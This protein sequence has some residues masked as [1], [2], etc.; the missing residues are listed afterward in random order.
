MPKTITQT[1]K[2]TY[3][4]NANEIAEK[5]T[6]SLRPDRIKW[7]K[8]TAAERNVAYSDIVRDLVDEARKQ[9]ERESMTA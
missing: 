7:I 6:I 1:R 3:T 8:Q 5:F 9:A 4:R 2:R